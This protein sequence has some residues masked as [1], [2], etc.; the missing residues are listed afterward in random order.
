MEEPNII[1]GVPVGIEDPLCVRVEMLLIGPDE[2]I[3]ADCTA[4]LGARG[5][6]RAADIAG[7]SAGALL[8]ASLALATWR[9][10]RHRRRGFVPR[11]GWK[12]AS[13]LNWAHLLHSECPGRAGLVIIIRDSGASLRVISRFNASKEEL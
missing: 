9:H 5:A 8:K 7:D 6:F 2:A 11:V 12:S 4:G 13:G 3:S 1:S 10:A